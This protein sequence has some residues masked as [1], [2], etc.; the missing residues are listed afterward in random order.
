MQRFCEQTMIIHTTLL[1]KYTY[2]CSN[3]LRILSQGL[4]A[5]ICST[6]RDWLY[7]L[8][9]DENTN[10]EPEQVQ[11]NQSAASCTSFKLA[12]KQKKAFSA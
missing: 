8:V 9:P 10:T 6:G 12:Q 4:I 1:R 5:N 7:Y 11:K 2:L 3:F